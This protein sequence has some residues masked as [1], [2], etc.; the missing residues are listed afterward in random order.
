MTLI[1]TNTCQACGHYEEVGS[2]ENIEWHEFGLC[3]DCYNSDNVVYC[4]FTVGGRRSP[5][6]MYVNVVDDSYTRTQVKEILSKDRGKT[7]TIEPLGDLSGISDIVNKYTSD[8]H[9]QFVI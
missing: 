9:N 7:A 4:R 2:H 1:T 5:L 6:E 8:G 3:K